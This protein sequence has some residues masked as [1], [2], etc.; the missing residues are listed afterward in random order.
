VTRGHNEASRR[1]VLRRD[2]ERELGEN[3]G[4]AAAL[5]AATFQLR[6]AFSR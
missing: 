2:G 4:Q 6:D 5:I 1:E 3:L